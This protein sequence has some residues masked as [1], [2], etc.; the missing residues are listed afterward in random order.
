MA[1]RRRLL[2][3]E[4]IE[5]GG[6]LGPLKGRTWRIGLMGESSTRAKVLRLLAALERTLPRHGMAV[7]EG[8]GVAAGERV[9]AQAD[10]R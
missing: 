6:G 4:G 8:A 10:G 2:E 3:T 5:I 7:A 1:V 9:Y